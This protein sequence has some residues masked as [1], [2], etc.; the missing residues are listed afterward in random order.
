MDKYPIKYKQAQRC[1]RLHSKT[2]C[3][4]WFPIF[5]VVLLH[6]KCRHSNSSRYNNR[7]I[8]YKT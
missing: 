2:N 6:K 5:L 8:H 7:T 1:N 3:L 4:D